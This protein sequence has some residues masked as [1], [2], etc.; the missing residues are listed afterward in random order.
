M[1]SVVHFFLF[2]WPQRLNGEDK[3]MKGPDAKASSI[4][5]SHSPAEY[6]F[7]AIT[8]RSTLAWSGSI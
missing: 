4:L 7:I 2:I 5:V 8:P 6:P 1:V 3:T